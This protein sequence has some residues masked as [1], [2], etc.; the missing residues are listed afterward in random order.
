MPR[1][2]AKVDDNHR[3]VSQALMDIGA[4]VCHLHA[5]GM[6]APDMCV[7]F[8][9]VNYLLEIKDGNKPPSA[10]KLNKM[11]ERWHQTWA[12][13]VAVVTSVDEA[14]EAI[15]AVNDGSG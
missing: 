8:R 1:R 10:R 12:G 6:G 9:N 13:Q 7:G 4:T 14:L 5:V 3:E 11:Q 2:A 15:G